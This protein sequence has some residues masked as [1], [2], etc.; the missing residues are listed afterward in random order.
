MHP[1]KRKGMAAER[2]AAAIIS[3]QLGV[4]VV[5]RRNL[6]THEDIGDLLMP[7]T[8]IQVC[9]WTDVSA[10]VHQK[11]RDCVEQQERAGTTF[12][13]TWIRLRGGEWRVVMTPEQWAT[14]AREAI[15]TQDA[16]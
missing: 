3:D 9:N 7:D 1:N 16:A 8:T 10:A 13:C 11:P 6:G 15:S 14:Y 2:E 4:T 12:G 5:R